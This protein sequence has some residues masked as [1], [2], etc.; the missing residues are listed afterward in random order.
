L[1]EPPASL[2]PR[3]AGRDTPR[4]SAVGRITMETDDT[5][6]K[7]V[8]H[9]WLLQV[10]FHFFFKN[11]NIFLEKNGVHQY[12]PLK[13]NFRTINIQMPDIFL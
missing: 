4:A 10:S 5:E 6:A 7:Q 12:V 8:Q 1:V 3:K 2:G 11:I 13:C 9:G